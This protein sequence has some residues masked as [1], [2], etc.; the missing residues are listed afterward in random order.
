MVKGMTSGE[1]AIEFYLDDED[2]A[3]LELKW[4]TNFTKSGKLMRLQTE[5]FSLKTG[6]RLTAI[7]LHRVVMG[8]LPHDP[9]IVDHIDGNPANNC[10]DNLR[11][12]S[13]AENVC[14]QAKGMRNTSGFKGA[15]WHKEK[16]KWLA[17]IQANRKTIFLG[18]FDTPEEA[19][20]A[21]C[22]AAKKY[23]GEFARFE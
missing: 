2:A 15:Y 13:Q 22:R 20:E 1:H 7:K 19:H 3:L 18:Y 9:R 12:C 11:I 21:Y 14:N 10:K 23:H 5:V 6:K 4:Y 17:S 8:L 16:R